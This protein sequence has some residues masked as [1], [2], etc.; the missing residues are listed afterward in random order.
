MKI[1]ENTMIKAIMAGVYI[2]IAG[3]V[4]LS[5][6]NHIIGALLFS[7]G[8]LVVVTRGYFLYTGKV[9]YALPYEKGYLII[10]L[11][12]LL[13]NIMGIAAVAFL[14]RLTGITSIVTA[15]QDLF[16]A[17]IGNQWYET[18]ALAIFCGM[19]MYIAVDSFRKVSNDRAKVIILMFAVM[20]FILSK[21]EHSIANMLYFFLGDVYTLKAILYL[22]LMIIGNA[23][24]AIMLNLVETKLK[25]SV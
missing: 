6:D 24:G 23:I 5:L 15:G 10:L 2:G 9:G 3:I 17:K 16:V 1:N 7:F 12:T 14:F 21:F 18:L 8:L 22:F 13:G 20:I 25:K 4:Y 11:K 19:M